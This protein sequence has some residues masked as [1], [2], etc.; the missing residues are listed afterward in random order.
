[1]V[2]TLLDWLQTLPLAGVV[3]I[4]GLLVFG[5]CT[6][7]L[8]LVVPGESSLFLLGTIATSPPRF[9]AMWLVTVVCAVTGDTIGYVIGRRYGPRLRQGDFVRRHAAHGWD[10]ATEVLRT[11]GSLA[12]LFAIFLPVLRTFMPAVAGASGLRYRT[13]LPTVLAGAIAWCA[14]HIAVGALAGAAARR[15]ED[16]IGRGSWILVGV[17]VAVIVVMAVLKRRR[18]T[19]R[20]R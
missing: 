11:R 14:L 1:M 17:V 4:A 20:T 12:V 13:F 7:G 5:E 15:I 3:A 16:V 10:Q 19:A 18:R 6:F 2:S 9:V 8:G